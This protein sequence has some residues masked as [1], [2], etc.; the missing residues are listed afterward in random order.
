MTV[1]EPRSTRSQRPGLARALPTMTLCAFLL[2]TTSETVAQ[3]EAPDPLDLQHLEKQ[4]DD[5]EHRGGEP[6]ATPDPKQG[7]GSLSPE[8]EAARRKAEE[9]AESEAR[10]KRSIDEELRLQEQL[11][12]RSVAAKPGDAG[13]S[14]RLESE[15]L[16]AR[17]NSRVA[18]PAP[19]DRDYPPAIFDSEKVTIPADQ[20]GN[21]RRLKLIAQS[22]DADGDGK[23]ELHRYVDPESKLLVRQEEDRNYD[24]VTDTWSD[25]EWGTVVARVVDSNDDG[26]PDV[27]ESY[28]NGYMTSKEVDRDDDGVRDAFY[29]YESRSLTLEK[30]DADNDG[31]IDR[32]VYFERRRRVRAEED[33]DRNGRMDTWT[34]FT[35]VNGIELVSRIERDSKGRGSTDTFEFFEV[36]GGKAIISRRDEDVNGDGEVDI[37]SHFRDGKLIRREISDPDLVSG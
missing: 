20:W 18:P 29:I 14:D 15:D 8:D 11:L 30:H 21:R 27:W 13:R 16:E 28:E 3:G 36:R 6:A 31:K 37:I 12:R 22:L 17:A 25:Y 19:V 10:L 24:G 9:E 32:I 2:L 1:R 35:V 26:N 33:L 7:E 34:T 5:L 23:P 4:L